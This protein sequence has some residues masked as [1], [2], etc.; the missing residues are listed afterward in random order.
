MRMPF[1]FL[2]LPLELRLMIYHFHLTSHRGLVRLFHRETPLTGKVRTVNLGVN[3]LLVCRQIHYEAIDVLYAN[4]TFCLSPL[5][6]F[7]KNA[8]CERKCEFY[9]N[10]TSSG[11]LQHN[12]TRLIEQMGKENRARIRNVEIVLVTYHTSC[13]NHMLPMSTWFPNLQTQTI[14]LPNLVPY[15]DDDENEV[16]FTRHHT[17]L[18]NLLPES[19]EM[20][21][22][23]TERYSYRDSRLVL[24]LENI[25]K[26]FFPHILGGN[27]VL[28]SKSKFVRKEIE[29]EDVAFER[30]CEVNAF[31]EEEHGVETD[32][33]DEDCIDFWRRVKTRL[34]DCIDDESDMEIED[35]KWSLINAA[36]DKWKEYDWDDFANFLMT[37]AMEEDQ[38]TPLRCQCFGRFHLKSPALK[39]PA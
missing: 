14:F 10:M 31:L 11:C 35:E 36:Y 22:D 17:N 13:H 16:L 20:Y 34:E 12:A 15:I 18:A 19:K 39:S 27:Q 32:D 4:N 6:V 28:N 1:R 3:L 23:L 24:C 38:D 29:D 7:D 26:S 5:M 33:W 21:A 30:D 37:R 9:Q 2:D 8:P 25:L